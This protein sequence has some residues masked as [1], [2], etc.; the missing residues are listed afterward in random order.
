MI[1]GIDGG[2]RGLNIGLNIYMEKA[3]DRVEWFFIYMV[4]KKIGFNEEFVNLIQGCIKHNGLSLLI[5]GSST[6]FFMTER[7]LR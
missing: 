5:N 4:L 3:F 6:D 1:Q 7:G 2:G